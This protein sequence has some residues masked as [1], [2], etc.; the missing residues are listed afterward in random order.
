MAVGWAATRIA[1]EDP[2][3]VL[4]FLPAD[5]LIPDPGRFSLA[6]RR[7]ARAAEEAEVLVTLGVQPTRPETGYGYI[8]VGP[9]AGSRFPGVHRVLR[10]VEKPSAGRAHRFLRDGGFLWNA[11]IFVWKARVI[12]EEIEGC[13]PE[14]WRA[15]GPVRRRPSG[16]G[17][18][19]ALEAAYRRAPTL[20][21][22]V[23]VLERSRRVWTLPVDFRWSDVG[24]WVS[25]AQELGVG[26]TASRSVQGD[27]T[28]EE[29]PGNLV[30]AGSRPVVLLG[31]EGLA[32][33]DADD[34][35][36]VTGLARSADLR[37]VVARLR[38]RGR[39]DLT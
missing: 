14:L 21:I 36:L 19:E 34:A 8:R 13:A 1:A 17:A 29:A 39:A 35:L 33:I 3:A 9:E 18:R 11:G 32:V 28:F 10:F 12:L 26:P 31:V 7:A 5:H 27:V 15:L 30:W 25:L 37:R 24:T 4:A 2:E 23:A 6:L 22:D 38:Q 20:P 16:R